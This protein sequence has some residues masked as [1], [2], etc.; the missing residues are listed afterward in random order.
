MGPAGHGSDAFHTTRWSVVR[1]A[2]GRDA[3]QRGAAL[4]ELCATYW[5]PLFAWLRR[6]GHDAE[7]A[8]DLVQGFVADL[9]GGERLSHAV[10][11]RF[12]SYVLGALRHWV[13]NR[14]RH[15]RAQRRGGGA[16]RVDAE[17]GE[18]LLRE[19]RAPDAS[20]DAAFERAWALEVIGN[21]VARLEREFALRGQ[22]ERFAVLRPLL[23]GACGDDGGYAAAAARLGTTAGA[24]RVAVHRARDR[25]GA[26][27]REQLA[28][29]VDDAGELEQKLGELLAAL[30]A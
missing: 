29:T 26:L 6:D 24:L 10:E 22:A 20:P 19:L 18:N 7:S 21:A 4:G 16:L 25:L 17:A 9:L 23:D 28:D 8:A 30:Q 27:L 14:R 15:E 2:S 3:S 12:R 11:G 5:R 1:R 13:A